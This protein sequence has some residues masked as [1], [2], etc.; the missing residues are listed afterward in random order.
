MSTYQR[1]TS[2]DA[3]KAVQHSKLK[4]IKSDQE[5]TQEEESLKQQVVNQVKV[6]INLQ[7]EGQTPSPETQI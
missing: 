7:P 6:I 1:G 4:V 3:A 2:E 5:G